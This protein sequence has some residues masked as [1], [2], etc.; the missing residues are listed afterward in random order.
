MKTFSIQRGL[1][2]PP[3]ACSSAPDRIDVFAVVGDG[4]V[5]RWPAVGTIWL[6]P[7]PLAANGSFH[8]EG[9]C[10]VSSG[11]GRVE[12]F[13]V[14]AGSRTPRWWRGDGARWTVGPNLNGPAVPAVPVAAVAASPAD[15]DVFS[16]SAD[17]T[18][19]PL[20]WHWDGAT[21]AAPNKLP[22]AAGVRFP[23]ERIS[24]VSGTP[25]RLDV[26]AVGSDTHLWHWWK[27]GAT[28]WN[29][30]NLGGN[31]PSEGVG[32]VSWGPG[33]IDVFAASSAAG[34]PLQHWWTDGTGFSGPESL[35]GSLAIGTVSA[36]S[37]APGRLDIFAVSGQ[38]RLVHWQWD[39]QRWTGPDTHGDAI[40]AGDVSAVV[41]APHRLDVFVTGAGN[42][43]RKW[44][45]GGLENATT[46]PWINWPANH[47]TSP[48]G[49]L[50][51]DSL[52]ELVNIV[53]EAERLGRSVRA[54]GSGW[55]NSDVAVTP[56]QPPGYV[57]ETDNLGAFLTDVLSATVNSAGSGMHLVH[58]EAGIKLDILVE[59]LFSARDFELKTLGGST[60]QSLAGAVSTSVHGMDVDRGPLPDMVRA[61]HLVGPGGVQHWIE[62]SSRVITDRNKLRYI[63]GLT[64]ENIHY[65]DD[66]FYSVLVSMGSMG[67]IYS[68]ILEVDPK[69]ALKQTRITIDWTDIRAKLAGRA[70]N[71]LDSNRGVQVVLSP[72]P[73]GDGTRGCYLTTRNE[74]PPVGLESPKDDTWMGDLL[75]P[76]LIDSFQTNHSLIDDGVNT[77]TSEKQKANVTTAWAHHLAGG[78][79]PGSS[80]GL[81]VEFMFDTSDTRYLDFVDAALEILG[82][83]YYVEQPSLGYLGWISMRFQGR[84]AAYLSPQHHSDR[85]CSIEFAAAMHTRNLAGPVVWTDTPVLL[86]RIEEKGRIFG[87]IQHW[88]MND[89]I[90]ASDV[91][92]AYPRLDTWRR[93][94]WELTKGGTI[95]T[96]DNAFTR[97]CGLSEP[98][99]F[100]GAANF[101][102]DGKTDLAV[103]R[104]GTGTW[105]VVNSATGSERNQQW[106]QV[107]D[108][109]VPG[110]Y[111][112]DGKVD[113]AVWRPRT[114]TWL[115]IDS[116]VLA[117]PLDAFVGASD[118]VRERMRWKAAQR[119]Q[120]WGQLG[121]IPVPGD[122]DGD[123]KTDFAVWRPGTGTW[124]VID[125]ATGAQRSEQWG[126]AGDIPVPGRYDR[127]NTTDFA[128]W[129][130]SSGTWFVID[131][132]TG[133]KRSQQWGQAGDIPVPGDYD[134][135]GKTDF[136]VWRPSTGTWFVIDSS[137]G[138]QRSRQWG[139]AGDIPVPGRYGSDKR[140]DFAVWRPSTG[141]WWIIDSATGAERGVQ[142]GNFG[143][144][145]V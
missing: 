142:W 56:S 5:W 22:D 59:R 47:P 45:G 17:S 54:V 38:Q 10:A 43:L 3:S 4:S 15:I 27:A 57:I 127:D 83:A 94:R 121:D 108:I 68:L 105:W 18:G 130:P 140:T 66:W 114:G 145:P 62:P 49:L 117:R 123:G 104:P 129:R 20:W 14:D 74:V 58:V 86:A 90:D 92:R 78:P 111:D 73:R 81:T 60:G 61:I 70:D 29:L 144:I 24:A 39:G 2:G 120:Q 52:E 50:R 71:P 110:D 19:S 137:T 93:V 87:G 119:S 79:Y 9:L 139:M 109:P 122:Y 95:T 97:R 72:Y 65:D 36:V 69:Y 132:A 89:A 82:K 125:S 133:A 128:V 106:G 116:S 103:W 91:V 76:L 64:D 118:R 48:A 40:P 88:G 134:G 143:D 12:V 115:V 13:A 7:A 8:P 101:D 99:A 138:V 100:V 136:A 25:G 113:F 34:N 41:R 51:P 16:V 28:P 30:E 33:R 67:I 63:L 126:Q 112:G 98:P 124:F 135:D 84:S 26:F 32:A 96:F 107:G 46:G 6:A 77:V 42:T 85:T 23:A 21:W 131:S 1:A 102:T 37:H 53:H 141:M 55:S 35:G 44:P 31:L 80:R 11:P 75:T